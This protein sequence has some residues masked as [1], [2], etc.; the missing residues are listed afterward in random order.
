MRT[1]I[2]IGLLL[3]FTVGPAV[4]AP[5]VDGI[6]CVIIRKLTALERWYWRKRLGLTDEQVRAIRKQCRIVK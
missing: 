1:L 2:G 4:P 5:F 6:D 3:W